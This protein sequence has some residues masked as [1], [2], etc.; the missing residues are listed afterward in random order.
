MDDAQQGGFMSWAQDRRLRGSAA[1]VLTLLALFL[2]VEVVKGVKEFK[3]IGGGVPV[4]N[5]VTITG[6]G[7]VFAV[8]DIAT[9]SFSVIEEAATVG[10]AQEVATEKINAILS[11]LKDAGIED[12]D[13][14]TLGYNVYPKYSYDTVTCFSYPCPPMR[15]P[16]I[17][18]YE[19][20]QTIEIKVRDTEQA[21]GLLS[22]IGERGASN[23]SG[24]NFTIDDEDAL[25]SEAREQAIA[26]AKEKAEELASDLGVRLVRVVSFYEEENYPYGPI[27]Y[28][29]D[30]AM[31]MG[32]VAESMSVAPAL[33]AGENKIISR[34][35]ITYEIR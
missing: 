5:V 13:I 21:G 4:T 33:P 18:G 29:Y 28:G 32:G 16:E 26:N 9:F 17:S 3:Y 25:K 1:L 24:V 12:K 20:S 2:V 22:N 8:P 14:K 30:K 34:V 35:N 6:E 10:A 19:V 11:Y 15:D 23:L 31:G 27:Y 7:E